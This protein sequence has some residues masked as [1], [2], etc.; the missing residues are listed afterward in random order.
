MMMLKHW[1]I[2]LSQSW[3][4]FPLQRLTRKPWIFSNWF[5]TTLMD[6]PA[7]APPL[8]SGCSELCLDSF[9]Y[10]PGARRVFR[11]PWAG[12][13]LQHPWGDGRSGEKVR[14]FGA[15]GRTF[16]LCMALTQSPAVSKEKRPRP[17]PPSFRFRYGALRPEL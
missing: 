10:F 2:L 16:D 12:R 14:P 1:A 5:G 3:D 11:G 13:R 6:A 8:P 7:C 15:A 4:G 9:S 17:D